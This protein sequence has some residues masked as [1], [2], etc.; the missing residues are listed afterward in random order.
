MFQETEPVCRV[1]HA[2]A[3]GMHFGVEACRAC[4]AFFR[5]SINLKR[6]Y[7]CRSGSHKC[8]LFNARNVCRKC[9]LQKCFEV[10][11]LEESMF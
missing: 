7:V 4:A 9:R 6:R 10:G 3:Q 2:L 8:K 1:C 5:R 11:M